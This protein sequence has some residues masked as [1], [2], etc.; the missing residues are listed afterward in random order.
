MRADAPQE[1]RKRSRFSPVKPLEREP[2]L[3][4]RSQRPDSLPAGSEP[5]PAPATG[6][7][8]RA[9]PLS[10]GQDARYEPN[11]FA[12]SPSRTARIRPGHFA[13]RAYTGS[14]LR[15]QRTADESGHKPGLV[16]VRRQPQRD[17]VDAVPLIRG[18]RVT[19]PLERVPDATHAEHTAP[20][21]APSRASGPPQVP[22]HRSCVHRR[23][24]ANHDVASSTRP[25]AGPRRSRTS[26][27]SRPGCGS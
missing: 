7:I 13:Q 20:P 6:P 24:S 4:G 18:S 8:C 16:L 10:V 17:A 3:G 12:P 5:H 27:R 15:K 25:T 14:D 21:S 26:S 11:F 1:A 9:H 23:S 19:L 2:G 22:P